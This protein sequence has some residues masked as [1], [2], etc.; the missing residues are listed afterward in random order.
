MNLW[1]YPRQVVPGQPMQR[2]RQGGVNLA[3]HGTKLYSLAPPCNTASPEGTAPIETIDLADE[4]AGWSDTG[5]GLEMHVLTPH[6]AQ[7]GTDVFVIGGKLCGD[8][9]VRQEVQYYNLETP[10]V[11]ATVMTHKLPGNTYYTYL[12]STFSGSCNCNEKL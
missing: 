3:V 9:W 2:P 1:E 10:E 8:S 6:V 12:R 4:A 7:D 11:N 5:A